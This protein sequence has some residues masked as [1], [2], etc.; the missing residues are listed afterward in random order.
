MCIINMYHFIY[1]FFF[2]RALLNP[3][4]FPIN[5]LHAVFV[6][7]NHQKILND[8]ICV[9]KQPYCEDSLRCKFS[10]SDV[11]FLAI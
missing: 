2:I 5:S 3:N 6:N 1:T 10:H 8:L 9:Y 7:H 11:W 4:K